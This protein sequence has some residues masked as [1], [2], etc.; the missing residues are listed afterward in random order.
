MKHSP[1]YSWFS[2]S[3]DDQ[4]HLFVS[5]PGPMVVVVEC[6]QCGNVLG[7]LLTAGPLPV[8]L[9]S[10]R[11]AM[12]PGSTYDSLVLPAPFYEAVKAGAVGKAPDFSSVHAPDPNDH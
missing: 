7:K 10:A 9:G 3:A 4:T 8:P 2:C 12:R 11:G 5:S 1:L 6:P